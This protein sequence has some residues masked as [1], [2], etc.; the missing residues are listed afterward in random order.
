MISESKEKNGVRCRILYRAQSAI[1]RTIVRKMLNISRLAAHLSSNLVTGYANT[2]TCYQP[3]GSWETWPAGNC[4]ACH[5]IQ[6]LSPNSKI[7]FRNRLRREAYDSEA[8]ESVMLV[9]PDLKF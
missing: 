9:P 3:S 4:V 2:V 8:A 6:K 5:Q 1:D 7:A